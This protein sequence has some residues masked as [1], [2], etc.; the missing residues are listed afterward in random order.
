MYCVGIDIFE[1]SLEKSKK[2]K[3][4]NEYYEIDYSQAEKS[5]EE[6]SFDCVLASDFIEH[7]EKEEGYRLL[8]VVEKL[9]RKKVIIFTPNGFFL[10]EK[11]MKI[12]G[13]SIGLDGL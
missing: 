9:A 11:G 1:H 12:L 2:K 10:M 3:I 4:H 5:F 6:N 7:L 8:K 13:N